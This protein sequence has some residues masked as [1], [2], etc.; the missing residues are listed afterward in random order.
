MNLRIL[1]MT[2]YIIHSTVVHKSR[3]GLVVVC[4]HALCG[5]LCNSYSRWGVAQ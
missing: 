2:P 1:E 4:V 5:R 3:R